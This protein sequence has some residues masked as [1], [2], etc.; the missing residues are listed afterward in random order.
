LG[1]IEKH[2]LQAILSNSFFDGETVVN[3][4]EI[5]R[6]EINGV[7]LQQPAHSKNVL[8]VNPNI[9]GLSVTT[10]ARTTLT[11]TGVKTEVKSFFLYDLP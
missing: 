11:G 3:A 8:V 2:T 7:G 9:T 4:I 1:T 10:V 6:D 5:L